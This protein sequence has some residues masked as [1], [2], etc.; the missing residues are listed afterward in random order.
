[1]VIAQ[2]TL[3]MAQAGAYEALKQPCKLVI[4]HHP[5][6]EDLIQFMIEMME[7]HKGQGLAAPQIGLDLQI[8]VMKRM[9]ESEG[10]VNPEISW[11]S[12]EST[13]SNEGCLSFP[14][15][16][17]PIFRSDSIKVRSVYDGENLEW[18]FDGTASRCAQHEIDHLHGK[19]FVDSLS[20]LNRKE[21]KKIAAQLK[22]LNKGK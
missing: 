12:E 4:G 8:F 2:A 16:Q 10:F 5:I 15:I 6:I 19:C 22:Q 17:V 14:G 9:G 1:V 13:Y 18:E 21:R 20:H 11:R 7:K 3:I